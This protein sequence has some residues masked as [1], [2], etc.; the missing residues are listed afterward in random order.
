[1]WSYRPRGSELSSGLAGICTKV[2]YLKWNY[3]IV[4][5]VNC[6][7]RVSINNDDR[8]KLKKKK[9]L[10]RISQRAIDTVNKKLLK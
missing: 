4:N 5:I 9:H 8:V 3:V 7:N 1:M 10:I 2:G 6:I